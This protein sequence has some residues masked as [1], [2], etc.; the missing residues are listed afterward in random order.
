MHSS[1]VKRNFTLGRRRWPGCNG[2]SSAFTAGCSHASV[3][4]SA[5][6]WVAGCVL[7]TVNR[8]QQFPQIFNYW[9]DPWAPLPRECTQSQSLL[10]VGKIT[11]RK[12]QYNIHQTKGELLRNSCWDTNYITKIYYME[13]EPTN[14]LV[15]V[16]TH[17][18]QAGSSLAS[19]ALTWQ[20]TASTAQ[21]QLDT[22]Q[23]LCCSSA[24]GLAVFACS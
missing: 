22:S 5:L 11:R 15:W 18:T 12:R 20:P 3:H 4:P 21:A 1:A 19:F 17:Q 2:G 6:R 10:N 24:R 14:S 7:N 9:V 13:R 8:H 16:T 23:L